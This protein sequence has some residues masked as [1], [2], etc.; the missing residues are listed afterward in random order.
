MKRYTVC[1]L[2]ESW[3]MLGA[4]NY[5]DIQV[6]ADSTEEAEVAA[7]EKFGK[8]VHGTWK[9]VYWVREDS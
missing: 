3:S 7:E 5:I 1:V 4:E 9:R 6:E 8:T 2:Y